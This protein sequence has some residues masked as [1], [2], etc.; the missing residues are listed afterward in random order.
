MTRK[1]LYDYI[2]LEYGTRKCWISEIASNLGIS[3]RNANHLTY[4]LGYRRG[5]AEL[6]A[7]YEEFAK[8]AGVCAICKII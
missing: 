7:T 3:K 6:I 1:E 4:A 2:I 8:D 5:K